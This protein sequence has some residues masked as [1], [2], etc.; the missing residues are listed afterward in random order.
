MLMKY[1]QKI[2]TLHKLWTKTM[3]NTVP[4]NSA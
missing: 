3:P 2:V 4:F 1:R